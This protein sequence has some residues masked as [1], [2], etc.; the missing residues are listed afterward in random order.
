MAGL[1]T[2]LGTVVVGLLEVTAFGTV[3]SKSKSIPS[4]F[5]AG[6]IAFGSSTGTGEGFCLATD[7]LISGL[8]ESILTASSLTVI[9]IVNGACGYSGFGSSLTGIF[10]PGGLTF[11]SLILSFSTSSL[12]I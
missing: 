9:L 10:I 3:G 8:E 1:T 7:F 5:F 4:A 12:S 2:C 11:S 6:L